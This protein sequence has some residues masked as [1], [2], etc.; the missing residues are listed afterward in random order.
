MVKCNR[1]DKKFRMKPWQI[2]S[3]N[4]TCIVCR[5]KVLAA[6]RIKR[7]A[8][9]LPINGN[10]TWK[11]RIKWTREYMREWRKRP[12][13]KERNRVL[14]RLRRAKPDE[15]S[16]MRARLKVAYAVR[17]GALDRLPCSVCGE[18]KSVQAHHSNYSRPLDVRWLC[19]KC[20]LIEHRKGGL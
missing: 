8:A 4:Y 3:C 12:H 20:H 6:W 1:C 14:T 17:T 15:N 7:Q 5:R 13:V 9:G 16:K 10:A 18:K 19:H 11:N 2:L